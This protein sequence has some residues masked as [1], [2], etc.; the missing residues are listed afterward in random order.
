[1]YY[2]INI[3][4]I[5]LLCISITLEVS[6]TLEFEYFFFKIMYLGS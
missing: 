3:G 6:K 1:M 5:Q 2:Y 4:F